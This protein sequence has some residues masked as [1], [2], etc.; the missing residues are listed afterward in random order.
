MTADRLISPTGTQLAALGN[1]A[2]TDE[3]IDHLAETVLDREA[4]E[5]PKPG[6]GEDLYCL[7]LTAWMGERMKSV[8]VR[9]REAESERDRLRAE[10]NTA[11]ATVAELAQRLAT[12][13][14]EHNADRAARDQLQA[15]LVAIRD[16]AHTRS[17]EL[18][19]ARDA[20]PS[21]DRARRLAFERAAHEVR[22]LVAD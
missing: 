17:E 11:V 8:L 14:R 19:A 21:D 22:Q 5:H 1:R 6:Q 13:E 16:R 12:Q 4:H 3:L 20:R 15:A 2:A 7:N 9:L 18:L 10:R